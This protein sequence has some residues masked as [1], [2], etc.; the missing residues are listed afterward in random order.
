MSKLVQFPNVREARREASEWVVRMDRGLTPEERAAL[1]TWAA[2]ARNRRVLRE[3]ATLWND[4]SVLTSLATMFP[5]EEA[6]PATAAPRRSPGTSTGRPLRRVAVAVAASVVLVTLGGVYWLRREA[7][8]PA[9]ALAHAAAAPQQQTLETPV[10]VSR[11]VALEDGSA[12]T[13]NTDTLVSVTFAPGHRDLVLTRGEA[14]FRVAHDANSPFRV[15]VGSRLVEAVGTAFSVR[16]RSAGQLEVMVTEGTVR[17]AG[18]D[19]GVSGSPQL[20]TAQ[21]LLQVDG[22]GSLHLHDVEPVEMDIRLAWQRG[23]LIFQG[24]A[25]PAVLAEFDRYT[26]QRLVIADPRLHGVRV[27]GYFR[28]GDVDALLIALR[29]NFGIRSRRDAAGQILLTAAAD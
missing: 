11:Q 7:R 23:M 4:M 20:V 8:T 17:V 19:A 5:L 2:V 13:L 28:A 6:R 26:S 3:M 10:G 9:E 16:L 18:Q 24:E 12:V 22:D 25:L 29:E 15:R 21:H 14:H 27:G 1:Q